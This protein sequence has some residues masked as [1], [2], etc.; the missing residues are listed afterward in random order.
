MADKYITT[1]KAIAVKKKAEGE[2][3]FLAQESDTWYNIEAD[4]TVLDAWLKSTIKKGNV[5]TVLKSN[6]LS[7]CC[8][9]CKLEIYMGEMK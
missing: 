1:I 5:V 9:D 6:E 4:E 3:G 2:I 7:V 8:K